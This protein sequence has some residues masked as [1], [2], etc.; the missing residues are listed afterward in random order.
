MKNLLSAIF[1]R[2]FRVP[3]LIFIRCFNSHRN[4]Y[5]FS[6]FKLLEI[7]YAHGNMRFAPLTLRREKSYNYYSVLLKKVWITRCVF[8]CTD[9]PTIEVM[10]R[11]LDE[12]YTIIAPSCIVASAHLACSRPSRRLMPCE[13]IRIENPEVIGIICNKSID[14]CVFHH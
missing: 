1:S 8:T 11:K 9:S 6:I 3:V 12:E 13:C 5:E 2:S 10:V 7:T 4:R 14:L